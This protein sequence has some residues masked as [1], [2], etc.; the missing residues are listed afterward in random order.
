MKGLYGNHKAP[1]L[2]DWIK[3]RKKSDNEVK[4]LK[5]D[6]CVDSIF[7]NKEKLG[8]EIHLMPE[9]D[10]YDDFDAYT[11]AE[12]LLPQNSDVMQATK[13]IGCS[14]NNEE[15]PVVSYDLNPTFNT[16]VYDDNR[17]DYSDYIFLYVDDC[18]V[19]SQNPKYLLHC[20]GKYFPL[21]PDSVDPAKLYLG[22]KLSK[23]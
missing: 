16:R 3:R 7:G 19:V 5:T 14:P 12:V 2:S 11:D 8:Q 13:V 21:K 18:L 9:V 22:G 6:D 4:L 23:M 20:L 15:N 17:T 10:S 1:H